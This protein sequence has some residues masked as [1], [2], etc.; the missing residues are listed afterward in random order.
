MTERKSTLVG[1][2]AGLGVMRAQQRGVSVCAREPVCVRVFLH[3]EDRGQP[4]M[5]FLWCIHF[6]NRVFRW[7]G[8]LSICLYLASARHVYHNTKTF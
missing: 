2:M 5:P 8:T 3:M 4:Q 6:R 7:S 1:Q